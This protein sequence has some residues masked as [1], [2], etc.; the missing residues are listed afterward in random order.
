V[1]IR[2]GSLLVVALLV[3][4]CATGGSSVTPDGRD[5]LS[6]SVTED[7]VERPLVA[8]TQIRLGF[9]DG[10]ISASAGCNTMGGSYR[11]DGGLLVVGDL[12]MTE[13]GCDPD[14]HAQDDW[15]AA[16]L[17]A[18]PAIRLGANELALDGGGTSIRL[19]D[20]EIADPD[21]PLAGTLWTVDSIIAGDAVSS[22]PAGVVAT[23]RFTG[24]G[25]A[26]IATGCNDGGA[27]VE[28]AAGTLRFNQITVTEKFCEG[29]AG[30]ME[31]AVLAVVQAGI[32]VAYE[33]EARSLT[34]MAGT[35]G[36]GLKGG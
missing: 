33:I 29:P 31:T 11:I 6:T 13:M 23:I 32:P 16:F 14:R 30:E 1:T 22:V 4:A 34:L 18:R 17:A 25:Q 5:F 20:R 12:S 10:R 3:A 26:S 24:D 35:N 28:I 2:A 7:G 21:L 8:G 19:L 27:R 15:L 9:A 36:L